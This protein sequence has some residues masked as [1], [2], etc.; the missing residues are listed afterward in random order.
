L[1]PPLS[2]GNFRQNK[3]NYA[4]DTKSIVWQVGIVFVVDVDV[5]VDAKVKVEV[6]VE[7]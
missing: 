5:K 2:T 3:N 7:G 1:A 6:D 4:G